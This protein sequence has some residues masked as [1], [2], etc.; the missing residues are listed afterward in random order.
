MSTTDLNKSQ[1]FIRILEAVARR[2]GCTTDELME[3]FEL[4]ARTLRRYLADLRDCGLPLK[5]EH[6]GATRVITV[7]ASWARSAVQLSLLEVLALHFGRSQLAFLEGTSFADEMDQ[8]LERLAPVIGRNEAELAR[9]LDRKFMN[10]AE[11][12]KDYRHDGDLLDEI[13]SALLYCQPADAEYV[14][15]RGRGRTY[16]LEPLTLAVYRQGLYLFARDVDG[17]R[18]KS[19]AVERF[20]R[21]S[22]LRRERFTYPVAYQPRALLA[23]AF[24]IMSGPVEEVVARFAARDAQFVRERR[25]H[26]S[27]V[28]TPLEDGGVRLRM[29]VA[30]TTELTQWL[31]GFGAAVRVER[32]ASL[33]ATMREELRQAAAQYDEESP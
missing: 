30:V 25:W 6:V 20:A 23:D 8:A 7:D 29:R 21:F 27:A 12:A 32:P 31:L 9:D 3:R 19:F 15:A 5:D 18:V 1:K 26:E 2:G 24:G 10:V 4:D 14:P 13:V 22:R 16:R 17:D 33:V 28:V 11:H